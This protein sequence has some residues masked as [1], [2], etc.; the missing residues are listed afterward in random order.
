MIPFKACLLLISCATVPLVAEAGGIHPPALPAP[1]LVLNVCATGNDANDGSPAKPFATLEAARDA[2]RKVK[3]RGPLPRG[4]IAV[5]IAD[6]THPL[7]RTFTLTAE[8]SGT[9]DA[10]IVYQGGPGTGSHIVGDA[11]LRGFTRLTDPALLARLPEEAR[12]KV[13]QIPLQSAGLDNLPPPRLGGFGSGRG[14][15]TTPA[16]RLFAGNRD[17]PLAR[18]PNRGDVTIEKTLEP[19]GHQIHGRKGSK[20]GRFTCAQDRL[21][22]WTQDPDIILH[23]YWF[24]DWAESRELVKSINPQSREIT[25]E[26]P[27]HTYGYRNGQP[28]HATNLFSEI[29]EPG[30]W[31]LDR[32]TRTLYVHAMA[33]WPAGNAALDR[34]PDGLRLALTTYPALTVDKAAFIRFQKITWSG[35]AADGVRVTDSN[36]VV[37]HGCRFT[38]LGGDALTIAG[39][40]D[41]G[42]VSCGFD[43]TGRGAVILGGGNRKTLAAGR[44]FV[45]NCHLQHLSRIDPTYTPAILVTG[46][47]HVIAHNLIHDLPSSA[48]RLGGNDHVIE[49][50]DVSRVVLESD[51]QGAV[52]MWGDPTLRGNVFRYNRWADIGPGRDGTLPKLGRAAI[53][54]DDAIS[55]QLVEHNLF[56]NCGAGGSWFGAIQIHGGRDQIIRNNLFIRCAAAVSF[57]PWQADRWRAFVTPKFPTPELDRDL[58]LKRYPLLADLAEVANANTVTHNLAAGCTKFLLRPPPNTV[59]RDNTSEPAP[60]FTGFPQELCRRA[61]IDPKQLHTAGL[62]PD[63]MHPDTTPESPHGP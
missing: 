57:S 62:Y 25:L 35:T 22:R 14:F 59:D 48:I 31:Y 12:G 53:R 54:F 19:D 42:A 34:P 2:I 58:Y 50:N 32:A 29:D 26:P 63:P 52:D 36:H 28:F 23:G 41:C 38:R 56:E 20:T 60:E 11:E 43:L 30:E 17:L 27:F 46:V 47:G 45:T 13:W 18:W 16:V 21:A 39:G 7:R 9:A 24:W 15:H 49:F 1:G 55:G 6:G 10:P 3:S 61:G 51:D 8:D 44:H 33:D 40:S 5:R 37:F 4:G